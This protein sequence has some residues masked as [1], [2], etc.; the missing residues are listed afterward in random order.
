M[1]L[2]FYFFCVVFL[3]P[4]PLHLFFWKIFFIALHLCSFSCRST[5]TAALTVVLFVWRAYMCQD[6][7]RVCRCSPNPIHMTFNIELLMVFMLPYS[8]WTHLHLDPNCSK[9]YGLQGW[10]VKPINTIKI[11]TQIIWWRAQPLFHPQIMLLLFTL[12]RAAATIWSFSV[13]HSKCMSVLVFSV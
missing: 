8:P 7:N 11:I 13:T 12:G 4:H 5:E 2:C 9:L 3:S 10:L 6:M 1:L